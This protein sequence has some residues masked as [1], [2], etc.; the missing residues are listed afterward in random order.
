MANIQIRLPDRLLTEI[1]GIIEDTEEAGM[2]RSEFIRFAISKVMLETLRRDYQ[3]FL[4]YAY[5]EYL[6]SK[7]K[8]KQVDNKFKKILKKEGYPEEPLPE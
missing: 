7:D 4:P 6:K 3:T 2:K 5:M 8:Y 1:D